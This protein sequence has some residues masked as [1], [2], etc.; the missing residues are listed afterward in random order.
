MPDYSEKNIKELGVHYKGYRRYKTILPIAKKPT[1]HREIK[2]LVI[3]L[4]NKLL[5]KGIPWEIIDFFKDVVAKSEIQHE[6]TE[7][8]FD[9]I[10]EW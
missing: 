2:E 7:N 10:I 8:T 5:D 3:D 1:A 9:E 6:N 4:G